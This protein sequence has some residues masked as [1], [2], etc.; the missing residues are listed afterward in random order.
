MFRNIRQTAIILCFVLTP[1][2][3]AK[4]PAL[5]TQQAV[6]AHAA[7]S[8]LTV[9]QGRM[10]G[11]IHNHGERPLAA[12]RLLVRYD[13]L[14]N[15]DLSPGENSPGWSEYVVIDE[16]IEPGATGRFVYVPGKPLTTRDDGWFMPRADVVGVTLYK[17]E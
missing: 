11:V 2:A 7:L 3:N 10:Y 13:W 15:D 17:T 12:V 9:Q 5:V 14:W 1:V 8:A 6:D 16:L 4:Q